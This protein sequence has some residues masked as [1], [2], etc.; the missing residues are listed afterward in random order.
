MLPLKLCSSHPRR[1]KRKGSLKGP[2]QFCDQQQ[3]RGYS[4][5]QFS[6]CNLFPHI[7]FCFPFLGGSRRSLYV[8]VEATSDLLKCQVARFIVLLWSLITEFH[9]TL[10]ATL[11]C[12]RCFDMF[13]VLPTERSIQENKFSQQC[14]LAFLLHF[15]FDFITL[16]CL[17]LFI[18]VAVQSFSQRSI[19]NLLLCIFIFC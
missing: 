16:E 4:W 17:T 2:A 19:K 5:S 9:N 8:S 12:P 6:R 13:Y 3:V 1:R 11:F 7:C 10:Q 14:C 18:V 15:Y